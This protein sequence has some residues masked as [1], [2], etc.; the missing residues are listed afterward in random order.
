MM[1]VASIWIR[2]DDAYIVGKI[3]T[4]ILV[5]DSLLRKDFFLEID[6]GRL[7]DFKSLCI[8]FAIFNVQI[9]FWKKSE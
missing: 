9:S 7:F 4:L 1:L 2:A 5:S 8:N 3:Y 6:A